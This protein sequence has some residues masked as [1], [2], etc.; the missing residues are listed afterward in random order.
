MPWGKENT[1]DTAIPVLQLLTVPV[2]CR[3]A[4]FSYP[5]PFLAIILCRE[6]PCCVLARFSCAVLSSGLWT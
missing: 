2:E 4:S 3:A 5:A 1:Q 6:R